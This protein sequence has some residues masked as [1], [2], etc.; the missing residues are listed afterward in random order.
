MGPN[1]KIFVSRRAGIDSNIVDNDLYINVNCGHI[2]AA[3]KNQDNI[4][5]DDTGSNISEKASR[6]G[7][8]SVQYWAWKNHEADYYGLCHYRRYLSFSDCKYPV[9]AYTK[10]PADLGHVLCYRLNRSS[11]K[12]YSLDDRIK[13]VETIQ[14]YDVLYSDSIPISLFRQSLGTDEV[15]VRDRWNNSELITQS[16][17]ERLLE[18]IKIEKPHYYRSAIDY[19]SGDQFYGHNIFVMKKELFEELCNFEYPILFILDF[20]T[21]YSDERVNKRAVGYCSEILFGIF[22]H[23]VIKRPGVKSKGLQCIYFKK[24]GKHELIRR[25]IN[26]IHDDGVMNTSRKII[27]EIMRLLC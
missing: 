4:F 8:L 27:N 25:F 11:A 22:I 15:C 17:M 24:T 7:E 10:Y 19:L 13:M 2:F 16:M 21:D 6:F 26:S 23:E 18:L 9:I 20:E 3:S 14:Q 5:N 1:I 12:K